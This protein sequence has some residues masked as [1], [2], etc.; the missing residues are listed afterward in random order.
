MSFLMDDSIN[1]IKSAS[2]KTELD[3]VSIPL[4]SSHYRSFL[5]TNNSSHVIDSK[6]IMSTVL[7]QS[8]S[9]KMLLFMLLFANASLSSD[10]LVLTVP[11]GV[12]KQII[13]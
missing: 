11:S 1:A 8:K 6:G 2:L 13:I 9:S 10:S 4:L 3:I 5:I 12:K 7:M